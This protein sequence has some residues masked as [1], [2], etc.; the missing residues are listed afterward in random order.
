MQ[1]LQHHYTAWTHEY[2]GNQNSTDQGQN[3]GRDKGLATPQHQC[4]SHTHRTIFLIAHGHIFSATTYLNTAL[5]TIQMTTKLFHYFAAIPANLTI[6]LTEK[7][8]HR[9]TEKNWWDISF[10]ATPVLAIASAWPQLHRNE[11]AINLNHL[12]HTITDKTTHI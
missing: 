10:S 3:H 1:V 5:S 4:Y 2:L 6:W 11:W 7:F 8:P 9:K 12:S